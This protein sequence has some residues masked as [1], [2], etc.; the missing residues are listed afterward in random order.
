MDEIRKKKLTGVFQYKDSEESWAIVLGS[1]AFSIL[2]SFCGRITDSNLE[3]QIV[4]PESQK[5]IWNLV[6]KD[7]EINL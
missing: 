2:E 7:I 5:E 3:R 4:P 6:Y 1:P